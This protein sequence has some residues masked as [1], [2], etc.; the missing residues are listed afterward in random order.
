MF[1]LAVV[2][3]SSI[4]TP[5]FVSFVPIISFLLP[6]FTVSLNDLNH[7]LLWLFS[8]FSHYCC[9]CSLVHV[10]HSESW[11][12]LSVKHIIISQ[13]EIMTAVLCESLKT[14][15]WDFL[16]AH[17]S[18]CNCSDWW[19]S[20]RIT[21]GK[22]GWWQGCSDFIPTLPFEILPHVV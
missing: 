10:L 11:R 12:E 20:I 19:C 14:F 3:I 6:L 8:F 22:P 18:E 7:H 13:V 1:I 15:T 17:Y 2:E 21:P 5:H 9:A 4:E 16:F